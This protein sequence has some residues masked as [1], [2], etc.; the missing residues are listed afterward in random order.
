MKQVSSNGMAERAS[1]CSWHRWWCAVWRAIPI[2]FTACL[3]LCRLDVGCRRLPWAA[4]FANRIRIV[5]DHDDSAAMR[6][7]TVYVAFQTIGDAQTARAERPIAL[8]VLRLMAGQI[9]DRAARGTRPFGCA[10]FAIY[11]WTG[12]SCRRDGEKIN[13]DSHA[14]VLAA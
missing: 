13:H 14:R 8:S 3:F 2:R 11:S 9:Q 4:T 6:Q 12:R 1:A 5:D 7:P 10:T